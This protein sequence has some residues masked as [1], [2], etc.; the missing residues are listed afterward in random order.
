MNVFFF[1]FDLYLFISSHSKNICLF[2]CIF[3]YVLCKYA[4]LYII[5]IYL[6]HWWSPLLTVLV[7]GEGTEKRW[8]IIF[9][10]SRGKTTKRRW[11]TEFL[12]SKKGCW[13]ESGYLWQ[14]MH[15]MDH[16]GS[17]RFT[18]SKWTAAVKTSDPPWCEFS[19]GLHE[20][21][22]RHLS[23]I[24]VPKQEMCAVPG[25]RRQGAGLHSQ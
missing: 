10:F 22:P 7:F 11:T 4:F 9:I 17:R 1:C 23:D 3:H 15:Q 18:C 8:T 6:S 13:E 12:W 19:A 24:N 25:G 16:W 5:Y 2:S 20:S 21:F 14:L